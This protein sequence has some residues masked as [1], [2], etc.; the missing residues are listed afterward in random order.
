ME[1]ISDKFAKAAQKLMF[2]SVSHTLDGII[3]DGARPFAAE[4]FFLALAKIHLENMANSAPQP[5]PD[6]MSFTFQE[7]AQHLG[8]INARLSK[9]KRMGQSE[10]NLP[11]LQ[12]MSDYFKTQIS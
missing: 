4:T 9:G 8:E 3:Q 1:K 7:M 6:G 12:Q 5:Q 11:L 2:V 10:A